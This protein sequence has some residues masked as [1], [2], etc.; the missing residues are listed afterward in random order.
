MP[1]VLVSVAKLSGVH[2]WGPEIELG[3]D[4]LSKL[5]L[6]GVVNLPSAMGCQSLMVAGEGGWLTYTLD[7]PCPLA[8]PS[9]GH[10]GYT[11]LV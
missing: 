4:G 3:G 8:H 11:K 7:L 5:S 9:G 10:L 1:T 6:G 2:I